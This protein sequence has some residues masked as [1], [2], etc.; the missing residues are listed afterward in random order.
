MTE[1]K[2][3]KYKAF[4]SYRHIQ[5]DASIAQAVHTMVE[6]FKVPKELQ[7]DGKQSPFRVF[8]DREELTTSSLDDSID[9]ALKSSEYLIV[10]C[11][12]RLPQS[13]WCNREVEQ[14]IK[15]NSIDKVIPVLIEGEPQESFPHILQGYEMIETLEDGS[16]STKVKEILAAELRPDEVKTPDFIGYEALEKTEPNRLKDLTKESIGLL[17]DEKYRIMA[18]ILG[19]T[20]GDLRQRDKERRQ[21]RMIYSFAL[22]SIFMLFFGLFMFN[23]YQNENRAKIQT[24][25]DRS[26]MMLNN[27]QQLISEGNKTKAIVLANRAIEDVDPSMAA[28]EK[29]KLQHYSILNNSLDL[30]YSSVLSV[31]NT[32]NKFTFLD[33]NKTGDKFVAGLNN[34]EIGVWDVETGNLLETLI[35]HQQQVKLIDIAPDDKTM[36][37]GGFDD[38]ITLWDFETFEQ[39]QQVKTPGNVML[40]MYTKDYLRLN[41]IYDDLF[42]YFYQQYDA[43]TLEPIGNKIKL[44]N[45]IR[46]V[47]FIDEKQLMIVNYNT[48]KPDQS[49]VLYD[50][51]KGVSIDNFSDQSYESTELSTQEQEVLK[52][53]YIDLKLSTDNKYFYSISKSN[54]VKI[55][56]DTGKLIYV[57]DAQIFGDEMALV[58]TSD[59]KYLYLGVGQKVLKIDANTGERLLDIDTSSDTIIDLVISEDNQTVLALGQTGAI[60]VIQNDNLSE[61]NFDMKGGAEYIYLSPN[62]K[63]VAALSLTHQNIKVIRLKPENSALV[64]PGQI[65]AHSENKRYSL[66]YGDKEY[67]LYDNEKLEVIKT[68]ETDILNYEAEY[69]WDSFRENYTIS[70]DGKLLVGRVFSSNEDG[71]EREQIVVFNLQTDALIFEKEVSRIDNLVISPD[72]QFIVANTAVNEIAIYSL[73]DPDQII[74]M[75][76]EPGYIKNIMISNDSQFVG[77][78][79]QEGLS[80]VYHIDKQELVGSISGEI[81]SLE[82]VD[83]KVEIVGLYNNIGTKYTDFEEVEDVSLSKQRDQQGQFFDDINTYNKEHDLL[84]T[85]RASKDVRYAYLVD[86]STGQ[87]LKTYEIPL[88]AYLVKGF[89]TPNGDGIIMDSLYTSTT[90]GYSSNYLE[91][92]FNV[93]KQSS[94]FKLMDYDQIYQQSIEFVE[95]VVLSD[96]EI[97]EMG[98]GE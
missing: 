14:F 73:D 46:R 27:A 65:V 52:Y 2:N 76:I 50:L 85:I 25:Q 22:A 94:L 80:N 39:L 40:L 74:T 35:G 38:L 88:R 51:N 29:L 9:E 28:Y 56:I 5:P 89:V 54:L 71:N 3:Y 63:H 72:N 15:L 26:Q 93:G 23:A 36:V 82:V 97:Y 47:A 7:I 77:V 20:Y 70:N 11:S 60:K 16:T 87:L 13:S 90:I 64:I 1:Q 92:Q 12:K 4:I 8:R 61:A 78:N 53:P 33:F 67:F 17:K 62:Q 18:A 84:L 95:D 6:T 57:V 19:V 34:D 45:N 98:I 10:I 58:G 42:N 83:D 30:E 37:S 91:Q 49:I 79:Y 55:E 48:F 44:N 66:F 69:L 21:K 96:E 81:L 43:K 32:N 31:I 75:S 24:I 41:V 86:F 59:G 68:V